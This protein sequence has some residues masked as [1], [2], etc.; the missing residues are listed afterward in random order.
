MSARF[1]LRLEAPST[2]SLTVA[3]F[4]L[5][6]PGQVLEKVRFRLLAT[7]IGMAAA[8]AIIG[9]FPQTRELTLAVLAG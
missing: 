9:V 3:I 2:A 8:I 4:A 7:I 5:L 1:W 6:T